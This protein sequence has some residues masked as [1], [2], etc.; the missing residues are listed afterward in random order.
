L[1]ELVTEW[2][3]FYGPV[4]PGLIDDTF[5]ISRERRDDLVAELVEDE[6]AVLDRLSAGSDELQVCDR[7]NLEILLRI[8]RARARPSLQALPAALLPLFLARRHGL[9]RRESTP[10]DM[11]PVWETLFGY[12]L[13]AHLW[14]EEVLPARLPGFSTRW[15]DGLFADGGV[16]WLGCGPR[17]LTFCFSPDAELFRE[18]PSSDEPPGVLPGAAGKY[19]FW[20]IVDYARAVAPPVADTAEV[21]RRLWGLA[22]K[23][24]VTSDSFEPV[25]RGLATGF[26]AEEAPRDSLRRGLRFNRWQ[27]TRPASGY[28]SAIPTAPGARDALE[29]EELSRD[30]ARQV[31]RRC[32]VVFR[33]L[34]ENELPLLRWSRLF[35]TLRLMEF[36]GEVVSGRF[37]EG[38]AGVQFALPSVIE[39][40]SVLAAADESV[41]WINAADPASLCGVDIPALKALLPSRLSSTHVV[42]H[43]AR[44]VLVSRRRGREMEIRVPPDSSRLTEYLGFVRVLTGRDAR[45]MTAVH[46]QTINGEPALASAWKGPLLAAGFVE[47]YQRLTFVARP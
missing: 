26:R 13:A 43:G 5:G 36:S 19:S 14:E 22:W 30:R 32:G 21:A 16:A 17:R 45:A 6:Q 10:E 7:E 40:L 24:L 28:W 20:D 12:P 46:V 23:G 47:E 1:E 18:A 34:L 42:F 27:A 39:E 29:E 33:E 35:R 8:S 2:L 31:L 38:P 3:R 9:G 37:F 25:R 11:K 4:P 41:W 44:V 15:L